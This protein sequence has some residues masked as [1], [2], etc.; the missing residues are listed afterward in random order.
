M[1]TFEVAIRVGHMVEGDL[2]E[3]STMVDTGA[4][5]TVLQPPYC[6]GYWCSLIRQ[7]SHC[8]PMGTRLHRTPDRLA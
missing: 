2:E 7:S 5:D 1:G 8:S 4:T 6:N 3:V